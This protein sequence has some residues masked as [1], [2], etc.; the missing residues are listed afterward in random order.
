MID[1]VQ[2]EM[3]ESMEKTVQ[4]LQKDL[5]RI[6]TGRASLALLD[7]IMVDYY[8]SA[9]PINQLATLSIPE[10]RQIVIQPWDSKAVPDIEKAILKSELGL[11]PSND[12]KLVRIVLPPLTAERRKELVK[13]VKKMAEEF[14]VQ[15]R[16]HRRSANEVLKD[17][18]KEKEIT[19]DDLHKAQETVQKT[20][21]EYITRLD[22]VADE[23]EKEIMEI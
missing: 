3:K 15:L 19:E 11:N 7:G 1:D 16:N 20:T 23:K 13:L 22:G 18:K 12:G 8:G 9:T 10:P 14:K 6:R 2:N 17:L 4:A 5:K 21:D